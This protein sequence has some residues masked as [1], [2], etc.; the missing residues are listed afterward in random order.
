MT[1]YFEC[2]LCQAY[3]I[4]DIFPLVFCLMLK[5]AKSFFFFFEEQH[6]EA[7]NIHS[8]IVGLTLFTILVGEFLGG[9]PSFVKLPSSTNLGN[10]SLP[11]CCSQFQKQNS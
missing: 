4:S 11:I 9:K 8:F 10:A 3:T 6:S 7:M 5:S 1:Q 2:L